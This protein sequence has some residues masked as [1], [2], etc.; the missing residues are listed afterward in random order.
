MTARDEAEAIALLHELSDGH[1]HKFDSEAASRRR[2]NV[3]DAMVD[4][5]F[6]TA[7]EVVEIVN[8]DHSQ[9]IHLHIIYS[10][11]HE[12]HK[13]AIS[14][15]V[16]LACERAGWL[17]NG[18]VPQ[19]LTVHPK[20]DHAYQI[21]ELGE[22]ALEESDRV[23]I[24]D[25]TYR[26]NPFFGVEREER[27]GWDDTR[28]EAAPVDAT[29]NQGDCAN[30][31]AA[32]TEIQA[33]IDHPATIQPD[34]VLEPVKYALGWPEIMDVIGRPDT[35]TERGKIRRLSNELDGPIHTTQGG[36]PRVS[37][38]VLNRW[39]IG[40]GSRFDQQSDRERDKSAT[41]ANTYQHGRDGVVVPEIAGSVKKRRNT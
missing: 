5:S 25:I 7:R 8:A 14:R 6:L 24:S 30:Q 10:G 4:A 40:L 21:T 12:G 18:K 28:R 35:K 15:E 33:D 11:S 41:V 36:Q 19:G 17:P 1:W 31:D 13:P 26:Q 27:H 9:K 38:D 39:W 22:A 29:S 3:S 37:V 20:G 34:A 32:V 23:K 2:L 16:L